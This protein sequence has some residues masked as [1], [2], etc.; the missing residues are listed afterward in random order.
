MTDTFP[1]K[2]VLE[3]VDY[4]IMNGVGASQNGLIHS[5]A[6]WLDKHIQGE[7]VQTRKEDACT[8]FCN[9]VH[10]F[11]EQRNF[12]RKSWNE[13]QPLPS[14]KNEGEFIEVIS[15]RILEQ[16]NSMSVERGLKFIAYVYAAWVLSCPV[17]ILKNSPQYRD[18][19]STETEPELISVMFRHLDIY[20]TM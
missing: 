7:F 6:L 18:T 4:L 1:E 2:V 9:Y 10:S 15:K 19:V 14:L 12:Q 20:M 8:K 17:S 13:D 11:V 5:L 3:I 16:T